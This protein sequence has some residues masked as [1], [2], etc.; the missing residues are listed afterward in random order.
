MLD[1]L[2][3]LKEAWSKVTTE[4]VRNCF[5]KAH[6]CK[7][8]QMLNEESDNLEIF[9]D[10]LILTCS[11]STIIIESVADASEVID[12]DDENTSQLLFQVEKR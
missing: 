2:H 7:I 9:D 11:N 4:P 5:A 10:D 12:Y 8:F 3:F 6:F 1:C